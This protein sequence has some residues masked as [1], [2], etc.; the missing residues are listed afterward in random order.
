MLRRVQPMILFRAD[1]NAQIGSGHIM[2]TLSIASAI[3]ARGT[4]CV[5]ISADD[6]AAALIA[7]AGFPHIVLHTEYRDMQCELPALLPILDAQKPDWLVVDSYFVT[8]AYLSKLRQHARLAYIDDVDAFRY[9][10][11][12]LI[13]Y[14]VSAPDIGYA[15]RYPADT[16]LLLGMRYAPLRSEFQN[17][18]PPARK[19]ARNLLLLTGGADPENAGISLLNALLASALPDAVQLH[20]VVGALNPHADDVL[21][22]ANAN[23]RIVV[24]RAVTHMAKLMC[25]CDAAISASGS[26]LYELCACG[27]PTVCYTEA[28]NQLSLAA[29]FARRGI[30]Q[31]AGDIRTEP[32][33]TP[34]TAAA[35]ACALLADPDARASYR[36]KMR[37]CVDGNGAQRLAGYLC[38]SRP[39]Q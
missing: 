20:I 7:G 28:D 35:L 31:Y 10:V 22:L 33:R 8:P 32:Q 6:K 26:T 13:N 34:E 36:A 24:H 4:E 16:E 18:V 1:G 27:V 30:T 37:T 14:N 3:H 23:L 5:F 39:I 25:D 38:G 12:C 11:D 29:G 19:S 2:R 17:A 9:P 15:P 21:A